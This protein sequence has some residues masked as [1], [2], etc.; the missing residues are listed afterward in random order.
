M[1]RF[2]TIAILRSSEPSHGYDIDFLLLRVL[3]LKIFNSLILGLINMFLM[4]YTCDGSTPSSCTWYTGQV[5]FSIRFD[6]MESHMLNPIDKFC[7]YSNTGAASNSPGDNL[8]ALHPLDADCEASNTHLSASCMHLIVYI[9][10]TRTV[11]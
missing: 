8:C 1:D 4:S 9:V 5:Y 6:T 7:L 10:C 2:L 3:Q 11:C